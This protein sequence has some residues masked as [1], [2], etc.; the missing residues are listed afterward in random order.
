MLDKGTDLDSLAEQELL[1]CA[2]II[3][4]AA[5][6]L[7]QARPKKTVK[8]VPGT[9][10]QQDIN[11]AILDAA[12]AIASAT[13]MLVKAAAVAQSER[14]KK[15]KETPGQKKY[16]AD[17]TWANGLISAAQN[18][19]G[20]VSQLVKSANESVEGKAQEE[21]MEDS[22]ALNERTSLANPLT[23]SSR[24]LCQGCRYGYGSLG[25]CLSL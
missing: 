15:I 8:K 2:Q 9:I 12:S 20:A 24:C 4:D 21:G 13:G 17:P 1:K 16:M 3:A 14:V 19:A 25:C 5:A 11:D 18:V 22:Q 6:T 23:I 7:M 10:D